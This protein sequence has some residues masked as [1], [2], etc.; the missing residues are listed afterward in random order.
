MQSDN[1]LTQL[2]NLENEIKQIVSENEKMIV[3]LRKYKLANEP[4]AVKKEYLIKLKEFSSK[5]SSNDPYELECQIIA[6]NIKR[7]QMLAEWRVPKTAKKPEEVDPDKLLYGENKEIMDIKC[8]DFEDLTRIN[9]QISVCMRYLSLLRESASLKF[10]EKFK[11]NFII[12]Q[13]ILTEMTNDLTKN[14]PSDQIEMEINQNITEINKNISKLFNIKHVKNN[15]LGIN[16][17]ILSDEMETF[18]RKMFPS[19]KF[20]FLKRFRD[21]DPEAVP[22]FREVV[23]GQRYI[24]I[25]IETTKGFVFGAFIAEKFRENENQMGDFKAQPAELF[26]NFYKAAIAQEPNKKAYEYLWLKTFIFSLGNKKNFE[27]LILDK[28]SNQGMFGGNQSQTFQAKCNCGLHLYSDLILF[29]QYNYSPGVF[30][31]IIYSETKQNNL[32][33]E[34]VAGER[35]FI[36]SII[37]IYQIS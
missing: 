24:L 31:E 16:S 28:N 35:N 14:E 23:S 27:P 18:F 32:T 20:K 5:S 29:C 22:I 30:K 37:E 2:E 9:Q 6:R 17:L 15:F 33:S 3:N 19:M 8:E 12:V 21:V 7:S 10:G 25:I 4:D 36:P 26:S 11:K 1:V 13:N 34:S